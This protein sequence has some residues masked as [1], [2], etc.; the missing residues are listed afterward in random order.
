MLSANCK[1][2]IYIFPLQRDIH[3]CTQSWNM[4]GGSSG[5]RARQP[6]RFPP[7]QL[8]S[9]WVV[10]VGPGLLVVLVL[11]VGAVVVVVGVS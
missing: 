8:W 9:P 7:G 11:V 2:W 1:R 5:H 3:S 10:V 6:E 4:S